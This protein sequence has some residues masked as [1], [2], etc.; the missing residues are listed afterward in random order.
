M[1]VS[2]VIMENMLNDVIDPWEDERFLIEM[3]LKCCDSFHRYEELMRRLNEI[4]ERKDV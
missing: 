3:E 4:L 1:I 2:G